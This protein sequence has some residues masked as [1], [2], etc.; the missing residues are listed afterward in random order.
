MNGC[1]CDR[2]KATRN[3]DTPHVDEAVLR[4]VLSAPLKPGHVLVHKMKRCRRIVSFSPRA[5]DVSDTKPDGISYKSIDWPTLSLFLLMCPQLAAYSTA[6]Q[7]GTCF[8]MAILL[9]WVAKAPSVCGVSACI[10]CFHI[11]GPT[12][13][14]IQSQARVRHDNRLT[15]NTTDKENVKCKSRRCLDIR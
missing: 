10:R 12:L 13:R 9:F 15:K 7:S 11:T 2:Y 6:F 14:S 4:A 8:T 1:K 5:S 3:F